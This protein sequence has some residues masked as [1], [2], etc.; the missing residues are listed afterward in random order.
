M[1]WTRRGM[2]AGLLAGIATPL[3]AEGASLAPA[4]SMFPRR[5]GD[6]GAA[7]RQISSPDRL[8]AAAKLGGALG[9]VVADATTGTVLE[10]HDPDSP[11]PPASVMKAMTAAYA[12]DRLGPMHRFGTRI[13]ATGPI[14]GGIIQGDLVLAGGG[15]PVLDTDM[16]GDMAAQLAA[17]G[18]KG[19]SG[20]YLLWDAALPRMER[21]DSEQP[22][23]VGYNPA[24]SGLNLNFNRVHF[25]WRRNAGAWNL[26]MDA[27]AERF[28]PAVKLAR[29]SVAQRE[30]PLF[31]Y[32]GGAR[33]E[34]WTV[35][36]AALGK[37]GARWLPVRHP[38]LYTGEVFRTLV[39][40]HG[41]KLPEAERI[42]TLP[43][44][45][46][47]LRHDSQ[48][49]AEL[50]RDMLKHSTNLTAEVAGMTAS[51]AASHQ[52]SAVAMREWARGRHEIDPVIAD[53]SGLGAA[54]RISAAQMVKMLVDVQGGA[55]PGL[56]KDHGVYDD[57]G[58]RLKA[59]PVT[60]R[61]KTGTLNFV[62]TLAGY[63]DPPG[64]RR[65][66]FAIFAGDIDR[67][68]KLSLAER[69]RPQGGSA[70][71]KRAKTLQS[72]LINRWAALHA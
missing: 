39:A 44:G 7:P 1:Q 41:I 53:H 8:I 45:Q 30:T 61:A 18:I 29:V 57:K 64:G 38:A 15:D 72:Q 47:V 68:A 33:D 60:V 20:R 12:L 24:I 46:E 37:G 54:S 4:T 70:W 40:S 14:S 16:L 32:Q 25:E 62:S 27:R 65:L 34:S 13:L 51:Q 9:F 22:D 35:A 5:R 21:I 67:R 26:T 23:F 66:A 48:P 52:A 2:L 63:I 69:E 71:N 10:A 31:T 59:H 42:D 36:S 3:L 58:A 43:E 17:R 56:L 11:L 19:V 55:L 28:T 50:L 49:L 6:G